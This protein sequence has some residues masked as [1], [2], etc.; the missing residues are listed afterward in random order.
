MRAA[1][2]FVQP[3]DLDNRLAELATLPGVEQDGF[4]GPGSIT[5]SIDR[6]AA[7]F[8][9][10]GRAALLQL[11]HPWVAAGL[12]DHSNL[13]HDAI[14]RFHST[15]RVVYT[16]LFGT[17]A[18]ARAASR[19]MYA[20]HTQIQ[21]DL[22]VA[23]GAY[24]QHEPYKANEVAALRWVFAT[25]VESAMLAY[26]FA[27]PPRTAADRERYF[28]ESHRMAALCGIPSQALPGSWTELQQYVAAMMASPE[29]AVGEAARRM[30][31][32]VLSGVGTW[33][34]APCWYRAL[35]ASWLPE[36]LRSGFGLNFGPREQRSL[37]RAAFWLPRLYAHLPRAMRF[38]G[39][40]QEAQ[41]RLRGRAPGRFTQANNR[42]WM[43][44]T[45]LLFPE[46]A[47]LPQARLP[48]LRR[49]R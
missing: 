13:M 29:L 25:L 8:L 42:F 5:W 17:T 44:R 36:P 41:A 1:P 35:T 30:G 49:N 48:H 6:E 38:V 11:A 34:R 27:L 45:R 37:Q 16:M 10:A 46:Q 3:R 15:F 24:S 20:V 31:Q 23:I 22:P 18:Q 28:R 4:F 32:A 40:Y 14:G 9:G 7:V 2:D 47:S 12:A 33:V 43:G 19:Q 26:E 39:P 21:G